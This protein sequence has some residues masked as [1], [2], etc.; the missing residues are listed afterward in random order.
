MPRRASTDP[1]GPRPSATLRSQHVE[2]TRRA[3][4]AAARSAFGRKGYAQTSVD[5]I[6]A[7]A[8]VTKGRGA[9]AHR[10]PVAVADAIVNFVPA[11]GSTAS[12]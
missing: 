8:R 7:A 4:L 11:V 10:N 3:V 1:S 6:A 12:A 5:E 2:D 9:N